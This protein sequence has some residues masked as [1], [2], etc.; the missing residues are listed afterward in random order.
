MIRKLGA[1]TEETKGGL[2]GYEHNLI[3]QGTR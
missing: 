2:G 1:V 3:G